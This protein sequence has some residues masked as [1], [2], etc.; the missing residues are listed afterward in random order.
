[1]QQQDKPSPE[2]AKEIMAAGSTVADQPD[3]SAVQRLVMDLDGQLLVLDPA[4]DM[5]RV[6]GGI[7]PEGS[8]RVARAYTGFAVLRVW[9]PVDGEPGRIVKR[10]LVQLAEPLRKQVTGIELVDD[11]GGVD[12]GRAERTGDDDV[13]QRWVQVKARLHR[14]SFPVDLGTFTPLAWPELAFDE[15]GVVALVIRCD[16]QPASWWVSVQ[17]VVPGGFA[18]TLVAE[19]MTRSVMRSGAP[20][21]VIEAVRKW[22]VSQLPSGVSERFFAF[23]DRARKYIDVAFFGRMELERDTLHNA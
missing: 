19:L 21:D 18:G 12:L 4:G 9:L 20:G 13:P 14:K 2:I 1:M 8:E 10:V 3:P 15:T 23:T 6:D 5:G 11:P 17:A 16:R 7:A 22:I